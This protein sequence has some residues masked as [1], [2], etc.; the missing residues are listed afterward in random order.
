MSE[1]KITEVKRIC[2]ECWEEDRIITP[3]YEL[4]EEK[5][6]IVNVHNHEDIKIKKRI[7]E[8]L[9]EKNE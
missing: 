3:L 5:D 1:G 9:E 7:L 8:A 2:G 6:L 4:D